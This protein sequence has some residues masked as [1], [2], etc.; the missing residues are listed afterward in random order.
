[1]GDYE[2]IDTLCEITTK[3]ADIVREQNALL[4]QHEIEPPETEAVWT[5]LDRMECALRRR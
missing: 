3:L 5:E 1:M 4:K 2:L